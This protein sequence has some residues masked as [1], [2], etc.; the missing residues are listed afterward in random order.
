MVYLFS[1]LHS[2]TYHIECWQVEFNNS[3]ASITIIFIFETTASTLHGA[4][5]KAKGNLYEDN[6]PKCRKTVARPK[7]L[8]VSRY[9]DTL[10]GMW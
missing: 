6:I 7:I 9:K 10:C 3:Y 4:T 2:T 5:C 8:K 1:V